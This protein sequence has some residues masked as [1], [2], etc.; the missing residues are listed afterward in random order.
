[1]CVNKTNASAILPK[2]RGMY[3]KRLTKE[4]YQ[5][6]IRRRTVPEVA[7]VLKKHPYFKQSLATLSSTDPHRQQMEDLLNDDIFNK[8]ETLARY[9]FNPRNFTDYFVV[10]CEVREISKMLRMISVG[11]IENPLQIFPPYLEGKV[12]FD[13]YDLA[14]AK[15]F[16]GVMNVLKRTPYYKVLYP[17]WMKDPSVKNYPVIEAALIKYYYAQVFLLAKQ[18]LSTQEAKQATSLFCLEAESYNISV[19]LRIQ[20]YFPNIYTA[21]EV[22]SLLLPYRYRVPQEMMNQFIERAGDDLSLKVCQ[23]CLGNAT[24]PQSEVE[25]FEILS[26]K[27]IQRKAEQLLHL[28]T[29]PSVVVAAF[30]ILAEIEKENAVNVIEGVRYGMAPEQIESLLE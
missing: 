9:D 2:A 4:Q 12:C 11:I 25:S 27:R 14:S 30:I 7:A 21:D 16:S 15:D 6:L 23:I 19:V 1:M 20:K 17:Y 28:T 26:K 5:E 18:T 3:A 13:V 24:L 10:K 29:S 22:K 8:Y